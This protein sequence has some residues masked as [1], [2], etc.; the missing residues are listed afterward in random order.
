MS[1]DQ[2][3]CFTLP[4]AAAGSSHREAPPSAVN[5]TALEAFV[6]ALLI[7]LLVIANFTFSDSTLRR[8]ILR[9]ILAVAAT[10]EAVASIAN[11]FRP[12]SFAEGNG[13][14]WDPAYHGVMQDFGF[15]NLGFALLFGLA[16]LDPVSTTRMIALAIAVYAIHAL[17]HVLRYFRLYYGGGTPVAMR[18]QMF[19][20][21]D[22]L[23]LMAA[24]TGML[25][26]SS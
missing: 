12:R 24:V 18:P 5:R 9:G 11:V 3:G 10:G 17:T 7:A 22:G 19:E 4:R 21:R 13:R 6:W 23:Q 2:N 16:A 1:H 14:P 20:M 25:L 8:D 15:Y 26:F